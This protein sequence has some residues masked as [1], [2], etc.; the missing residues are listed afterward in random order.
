MDA[1]L[2][3]CRR[4]AAGHPALEDL[5]AYLLAP[6]ADLRELSAAVVRDPVNPYG[7]RVLFSSPRLEVMLACW[8]PGQACAPHDHGGSMGVVRI[9]QGRCSQTSW[10]AERGRLV[11]IARTTHETGEILACGSDVIH[12]LS[13][14]AG[15]PPMITLHSYTGAIEHMVVYDITGKRTLVVP[16][17]CGAWVPE[18]PL[19]A[20]A[21][22]V[23]VEQALAA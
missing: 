5:V 7:R 11:E 17:S 20:I 18:A 15:D 23:T 22:Y 12:A 10:R 3:R 16:G 21:G 8:N 4:L 14:E 1:L 2:D 6:G 19:R 9:L 13:T